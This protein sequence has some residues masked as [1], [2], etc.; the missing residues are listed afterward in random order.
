MADNQAKDEASELMG[1]S[2]GGMITVEESVQGPGTTVSISRGLRPSQRRRPPPCGIA[3]ACA[4]PNVSPP[5]HTRSRRGGPNWVKFTWP[6]TLT[7]AAGKHSKTLPWQRAC[8]S[9][10][11]CQWQVF[12]H[13][14]CL[15]YFWCALQRAR[16]RTLA[17]LKAHLHFS[18]SHLSTVSIMY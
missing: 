16:A 3:Y 1:G 8:P 5:P 9:E 4:P 6:S 13:I 18:H 11:L 15:V 14:G 10:P 12:P 7:R 2:G 17:A